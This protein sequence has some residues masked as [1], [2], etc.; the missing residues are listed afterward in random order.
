MLSKQ[1]KS[2]VIFKDK[3]IDTG[4]HILIPNKCLAAVQKSMHINIFFL[5]NQM[6]A[7]VFYTQL[8]CCTLRSCNY[9]C[10]SRVFIYF[11]LQVWNCGVW[12]FDFDLTLGFSLSLFCL[13]TTLVFSI[14]SLY[15]CCLS[16]PNSCQT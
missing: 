5:N 1:C 7:S 12:C 4:V 8:T 3:T 2:T 6:N 14:I 10:V 11:Y 16:R 9:R 15:H 13:I